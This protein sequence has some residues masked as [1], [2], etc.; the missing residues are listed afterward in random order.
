MIINF[1]EYLEKFAMSTNDNE[2]LTE[3]EFLASYKD[4]NIDDDEL[5]YSVDD[6][7]DIKKLILKNI[8]LHLK[9]IKNNEVI[10]YE[11]WNMLRLLV[12]KGMEFNIIKDNKL[13]Y[14]LNVLLATKVNCHSKYEINICLK[15]MASLK[16]QLIKLNM[17]KEEVKTR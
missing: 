16:L 14:Y 17:P 12:L 13:K 8:Y 2:M 3:L 9:Y 1:N 11:T 6:M 5:Y 7:N 15:E 10:S 4:D